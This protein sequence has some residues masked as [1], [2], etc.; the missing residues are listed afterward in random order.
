MSENTSKTPFIKS[1]SQDQYGK[2]ALQSWSGKVVSY[3]AQKDQIDNGWGWRYKVRILGDHS[4]VD[5]VGDD[6]L[7][8]AYA[9]LP[10]TAGSGGAYKLRS[11]RISQGDMVYGV[12]GG[13]GPT[14]ILGVFP[15][16]RQTTISDA[17]FGTKS[18]FYGTLVK[19]GTISGEFNEQIGPTTPGGV[20]AANKSNRPDPS[21]NVQKIGIDPKEEGVVSDSLEKTTPKKRVINPEDWV[22]GMPLN[23]ETFTKLE[24]AAKK[25]EIDPFIFEAAIRQAVVQNLID[26][27][28]A[29]DKQKANEITKQEYNLKDVTTNQVGDF[30]PEEIISTTEPPNSEDYYQ[31]GE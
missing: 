25:L 8:Y 29:L 20:S 4:N 12:R 7:S 17:P 9:L 27:D 13:G 19:N 18:G 24:E 16:T 14:L 10:T 22:V 6:E 15:R 5:N 26:S 3:E 28:T 30:S 11:A 2:K 21:G 31:F 1:S 23:T